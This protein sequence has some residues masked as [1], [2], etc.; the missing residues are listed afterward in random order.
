MERRRRDQGRAGV[1]TR[2]K[3]RTGGEGRREKGV[4]A[5]IPKDTEECSSSTVC[6]SKAWK[7]TSISERTN[8]HLDRSPRH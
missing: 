5:Y 7:T 4:I 1:G 8:D 2:G 3:K 6:R